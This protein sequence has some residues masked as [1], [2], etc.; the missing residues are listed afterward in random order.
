MRAP[1]QVK[2]GAFTAF[3]EHELGQQPTA[4]LNVFID[5][6]ITRMQIAKAASALW[7]DHFRDDHEFRAM[8]TQRMRRPFIEKLDM[9]RF[10]EE[11]N[12]D[13]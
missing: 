7:H 9:M 12:F 8:A 5:A 2:R 6:G 13:I 10:F 11:K 4:G 1:Y 3:A